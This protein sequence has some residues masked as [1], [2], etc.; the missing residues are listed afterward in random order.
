MYLYTLTIFKNIITRLGSKRKNKRDRCRLRIS[1]KINILM[2]Y[3]YS[4]STVHK[5]YTARYCTQTTNY[6]YTISIGRER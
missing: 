6:M 5:L 2:I 1:V 4:I 3:W